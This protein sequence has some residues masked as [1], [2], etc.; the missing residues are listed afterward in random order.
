MHPTLLAL[1]LAFLL[2]APGLPASAADP[3]ITIALDRAP[4]PA[5]AHGLAKLQAALRARDLTS[6]IV[7]SPETARGRLLV[8][9]GLATGNGP[10]ARWLLD[11]SRPF[12]AGSEALVIRRYP[13][14]HGKPVLLLAGSDARGLMYAELDV[15]DRV[16]WAPDRQAPFSEVRDTAEHPD[17]A[18]RALSLYTMNRAYWESR[19][20]DEGYWTR[21]LDTL[22]QNRF[23]SLVVVFGY[24]NGGFLA[25]C[26]PYFFDTEGFPGVRMVGITPAEQ[27]R[28]LAALNRL[29]RLAHDRGIAVTAGIWDHMYRGGVQGGGVPGADE[30]ARTPTT[31]LVWGV[32][33]TNLVPYTKAAL[34]QFVRLV[35]DLDGI[36]FRMHDESGLK[37]G[38]QEGFWRDVFQ[39]MKQTAPRLRLDLRAK[40]LPDSVIQTARDTGVDFRITTKYWM[41]QM[42][43]P[44][45][46]THINRPNQFDRRHS[47]ADLLRYPQ[48]YQLHWRLWNGGT[49]RI[50][51]W[52]DPDYARRFVASTHLYDGDGFEVNEPLATKMEGQP[53]DRKPFDLLNPSHRYYDYEFERY[54]HFFQVFGRLGYNPATPPEVW[55]REF[56]RRFGPEAGPVLETALHRASGILPRIVASSYPYSGFPMTAG[57]PEKQHLGDLATFAKAEGSDVQLFASFDAEARLLIEGDETAMVRPPET[58]RWFADAA[59]AISASIAQAEQQIGTH[60]SAEFASTIVDLKILAQLALYHARRIPAAVHYRL[61]ERTHDP[62]ALDRAIAGEE[63]AVAA[64]RQLVA[65]AGDFYADDLMMGARSR[66]LCGHWKDELAALEK[67]L[68]AL[69]QR[70][71][72]I[73]DTAPAT[74]APAY[75]ALAGPPERPVV[76]HQPPVAAAGRP[77]LISADIQAPGGVKWV[78]LRYRHVNQQEDYRSLPLLPAGASGNFQA[79]IPADQVSAGWDFMYF[80]EVMDN[81][82]HGSIYP[83]LNRQ[84]P[85]IVLRTG[86]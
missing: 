24:E 59:A 57:W 69:Q 13:P 47:Y 46:P 44:F 14:W 75:Q 10:A 8:L 72:Q 58:S 42:G 34:A 64:W 1:P 38:E 45:H 12:P 9:A 39:S 7:S 36:Q 67:G 5:A 62:R 11:D 15:A 16:G 41:E 28:N 71:R 21:Y 49:A 68:L 37:A 73:T 76:N 85:Y 80:L 40:G 26:Y 22:A 6:E 3:D 52:G 33:A 77:L 63:E 35:P 19:F 2:A 17:A 86:K 55:Q 51:L 25:P 60:R 29:I 43:L 83:D 20:Y 82:G 70:R 74:P 48:T 32:T 50:L 81:R 66:N 4:A 30:A 18:T 27:Q 23:N 84:T 54:W 56:Q 61:Y 78:R 31:H 65:A 79:T 53:H